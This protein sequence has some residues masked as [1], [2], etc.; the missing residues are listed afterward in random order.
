MLFRSFSRTEKSITLSPEMQSL[1]GAT[2]KVLPTEEIIK[3][4]LMLDVDLLYNGGLGTYIKSTKEDHR[5]VGDKTN[6]SVRVDGADVRAKVVG[7]GGNLGVTQKGRIEFALKGG[8]ID[9]D[10]IDNS[11][12]VDC[13]DREVNLKILFG[14]KIGRAHV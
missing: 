3:R 5:E 14:P 4:L 10:A 13:S 1:L 9:T 6:D 12:G 7:E 11:G 8:L 2:E